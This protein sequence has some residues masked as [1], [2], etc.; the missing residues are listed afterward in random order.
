MITTES[1]ELNTSANKTMKKKESVIKLVKIIKDYFAI[2]SGSLLYAFTFNFFFETNELA[3]GG[4]S[5]NAKNILLCVAKT[6]KIARIK[7]AIVTLDPNAFIIID[8]VENGYN[9]FGRINSASDKLMLVS[10]IRLQ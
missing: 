2:A 1:T 7:T 9:R 4:F 10:Y 5:G 8:I 3:M 6:S